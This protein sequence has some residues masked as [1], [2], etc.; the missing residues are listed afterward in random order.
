MISVV[1]TLSLLATLHAYVVLKDG[2]FS[3]VFFKLLFILLLI[4]MVIDIDDDLCIY[5]GSEWSNNS[6][7]AKAFEPF[8]KTLMTGKSFGHE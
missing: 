7:K 2:Y 1:Q 6:T 3:T 4:R 5:G 8:L